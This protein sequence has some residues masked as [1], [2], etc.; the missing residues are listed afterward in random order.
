LSGDYLLVL[1]NKAIQDGGTV[2]LTLSTGGTVVTG[3][4]VGERE[5]FEEIASLMQTNDP[6]LQEDFASMPH[7][8]DQVA[9][10]QLD[11]GADPEETRERTESRTISYIHLKNTAVL[12]EGVWEEMGGTLWRCKVEAVDGFW[13]G[14]AY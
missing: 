13:L 7:I 6:G 12:S 11:K 3:E 8:I 9:M 14:R 5:Y 4:M 1:L 10:E 2:G